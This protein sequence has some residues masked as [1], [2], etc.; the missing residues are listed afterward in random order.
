MAIAAGDHLVHV[1][2][3]MMG[4]RWLW[5]EWKP[6]MAKLKVSV[7]FDKRKYSNQQQFQRDVICW[8]ILNY[9]MERKFLKQGRGFFF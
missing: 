1:S 7:V 9:L 4:T 3:G 8:M 5:E 6:N 2:Q